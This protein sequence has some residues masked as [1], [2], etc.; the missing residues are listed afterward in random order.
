MQKKSHCRIP[1]LFRS[2]AD[3][4]V[5]VVVREMRGDVP[6]ICRPELVEAL[7]TGALDVM[8][9]GAR[10]EDLYELSDEVAALVKAGEPIDWAQLQHAQF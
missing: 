7:E 9:I 5:I 6:I 10:R 4:A 1:A 3:R 2:Y 8:P